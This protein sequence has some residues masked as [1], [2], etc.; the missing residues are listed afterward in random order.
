MASLSHTGWCRREVSLLHVVVRRKV[1]DVLFVVVRRTC[2]Q[3]FCYDGKLMTTS[4]VW[5]VWWKLEGSLE[6]RTFYSADIRLPNA[7]GVVLLA[8]ASVWWRFYVFFYLVKICNF[9]LN[10][11]CV[12]WVIGFRHQVRVA[13]R[14]CWNFQF[15]ICRQISSNILATFLEAENV[16]KAGWRRWNNLAFAPC[17]KQWLA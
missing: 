13:G 17:R 4:G 12:L 6:A 14:I 1:D 11:L 3:L 7:S 16:H 2:T 5:W 8:P 9:C 10:Y 15:R